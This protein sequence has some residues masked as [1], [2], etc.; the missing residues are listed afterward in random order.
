MYITVHI[1]K[2][3][4][5]SMHC[6]V[7]QYPKFASLS[8]GTT[9]IGILIITHWSIKALGEVRLLYLAQASKAAVAAVVAALAEEGTVPLLAV[10]V[11][12]TPCQAHYA[13]NEVGHH[14][15]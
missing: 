11:V 10:F 14:R 13:A 7:V 3:K 8:R 6:L 15:Q 1:P 2:T 12:N 5:L 4:P 9:F